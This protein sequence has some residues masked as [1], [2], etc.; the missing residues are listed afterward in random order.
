ML[1]LNDHESHLHVEFVTQCRKLKIIFFQLYSHTTHICQFLNVVCFQFLKHYHKQ[2][3]DVVVRFDEKTFYNKIDF[4]I[5]FQNIRNRT[6]IVSTVKS[7]FKKID[8]IFYFSN[9]VLD[10]IRAEIHAKKKLQN[11]VASNAKLNQQKLLQ[12]IS[13]NLTIDVFLKHYN[14]F[15]RHITKHLI[16][17]S[18]FIDFKNIFAKL[19]KDVKAKIHVET[20]LKNKITTQISII[21]ARKKRNKNNKRI[22]HFDALTFEIAR[23]KM[24]ARSQIEMIKKKAS[25]KR[26][27]IKNFKT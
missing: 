2:I 13:R 25:K 12:R 15:D 27:N 10:K 1:V 26:K 21:I 17:N 3:I 18:N 8:L 9:I 22:N 4:L 7:I 24:K 23:S 16:K 11:A 19:F 5:T 6:F 14:V 20:L